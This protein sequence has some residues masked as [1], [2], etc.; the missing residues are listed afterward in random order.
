M[1]E[2]IMNRLS[3]GVAEFNGLIEQNK[4]YVDK[5]RFIKKMMDQGRKYYFLSRPRR[6]GKTLLVS[7]FENFFKGNK[8]L[9]K[10]TYIYDNWDWSEKYPVL[11]ISMNNLLSS[12]L[13]ELKEDILL[14]VENIAKKNNIEL[15]ERG[16]YV[17]K[18][19]EL[20]EGL[21]KLSSTNEIVVL[22][23]E[24]DAPITDNIT[25]TKVADEN[26][27]ILQNFYN[28]LKNAEKY[29]K[30]VFVT[31]ISKF[32]K[33]SVFSKFNNLTE[34]SLHDEY[35]T[36]CGITHE[37][38][39]K[40]YKDHIQFMARENNYTYEETLEKFD[41]FYDGYSWDGVNN[42]FNPNSTLR[43][44]DEKKFLSFWFSTG[45]PGFIAE[46]FKKRKITENYFKPTVLKATELDAIDPDNINGTALLF[47]SG[48]LTIEKKIFKNNI[49]E[50]CLRI[51]NFEVE[52]AYKDNLTN[53]YLCD[54]KD[55][56]DNLQKDM[57]D[58]IRNGD[59]DKLAKKLKIKLSR[60]PLTLR[61]SKENTEKWKLY[62]AIFLTWL[63]EMGMRIDGEKTIS[64]GIIDTVLEE[65]DDHIAIVEIKYSENP[66]KSLNSLINESFKQIHEK[67]YYL[68][69]E[70]S[71]V[72]LIALAFKDRQIKNGTITD[73]KCKIE[74]WNQK[75][76]FK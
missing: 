69:Y 35:S 61:L 9:F 43:A 67:E 73:V 54:V 19:N 57:W 7:T 6:F 28:V 55:E 60:L 24:Y 62:S 48:Y 15:S 68:P 33:T 75:E 49:M 38:L 29:I 3:L 18:F 1:E 50:Y 5:T 59:C 72:S 66:N 53:I 39:K 16:S 22:I 21:S 32:T 27:E 2:D 37:E 26:R 71:D 74:K 56:F 12:S 34:L 52:Q 41:F 25:N 47:Q 44:L 51:P 30:F 8:K 10:D 36:I 63:D 65:N 20:I 45:T 14:M 76:C 13:E 46:I 70:D 4:I 17:L 23:D 64:H 31:G 58:W 40:Y 42:V 11:R